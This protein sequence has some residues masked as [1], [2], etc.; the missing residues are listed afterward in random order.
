[1]TPTSAPTAEERRRLVWILVIVSGAAFLDFLDVTVVNLAF[2]ELRQDFGGAEVGD[3][4]WVITGYAVAFAALLS[5]AGRIADVAGR[6]GVFLAGTVLFALASLASALAPSLG[7]LIA[8]RFL[9]GAAAAMTLPAG[10]GI[11]LAAS[12]PERRAAAIGIWGA[13]AAVAALVGPTVG[14]VLVDTLGWRSVFVINL[15]FCVLI[16]VGTLR[17]VPR[18]ERAGG[19]LPDLPGVALVAAGIGLVVLAVT[20]APEWGWTATATIAAAAGGAV[21]LALALARSRRHPAPAIETALWRIRR[22]AVANVA[23]VLMGASIY[24]WM[25]L[26]VLFMTGPWGFSELEAGL[27]MSPGAVTAAFTAGLLGRRMETGGYRTAAVAGS[28]LLFADGMWLVLALTPEVQFLELWLPAGLIGG[29]AMGAMGVGISSAAATSVAPEKYA[30]ATGLNL[31]ARQVG[32]AL[33]VAALAAILQSA[34]GDRGIDAYLDVFLMCAL[35]ALGA[36]V[37]ALRLGPAPVAA[38]IGAPQEA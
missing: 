35:A 23:S 27:A 9:Q 22:F 18:G 20:Q 6:R 11:V 37:V 33:G 31:T 26:C 14:G 30:A 1:M 3:L 10:L 8:A 36:A 12:P 2:P 32:G 13:A 5:P 15:P 29:I 28:L 17:L 4:A 38:R 21:A 25:L 34:I 16:L 24:A 7:V 19:R